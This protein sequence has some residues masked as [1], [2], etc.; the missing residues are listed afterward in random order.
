MDLGHRIYCC[1][2][3]KHNRRAFWK[4]EV[5]S[6]EVLDF[7]W[8]SHMIQNFSTWTIQK[9]TADNL[10]ADPFI[11]VCHRFSKISCINLSD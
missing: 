11:C 9:D 2:F 4:L 7:S 6:C 3:L 5:A 10:V 8:I 1:F